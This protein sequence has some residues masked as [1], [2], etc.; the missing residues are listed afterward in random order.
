ML[1][2]QLPWARTTVGVEFRDQVA[3]NQDELLYLVFSASCRH[4]IQG[5][6]IG[7]L[8]NPVTAN[9][10]IGRSTTQSSQGD[11]TPTRFEQ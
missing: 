10:G 5:E 6:V 1:V 2:T 4:V 3:P 11:A 7:Q 8:T 9:G